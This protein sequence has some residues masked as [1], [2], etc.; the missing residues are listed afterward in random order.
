MLRIILLQT[1]LNFCQPLAVI[2]FFISGTTSL[3][4]GLRTQGV[5]NL[6]LGV[7]NF[8]IFY[9]IKFLKK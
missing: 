4:L 7:T 2:A 6:C 8:F 1:I 5:I 9:G 3:L